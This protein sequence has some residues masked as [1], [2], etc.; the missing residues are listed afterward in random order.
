MGFRLRRSIKL[1]PRQE[2]GFWGVSSGNCA[3]MRQ[4]TLQEQ[5][6]RG[7]QSLHALLFGG[8]T[9]SRGRLKGG[10]RQ[11]AVRDLREMRSAFD[12]SLR[13]ESVLD[14]DLQQAVGALGQRQKH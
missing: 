10:A 1:L 5:Y 11:Q 7:E 8:S 4:L 6:R 2:G 3:V 13:S 14:E 9:R 12:E